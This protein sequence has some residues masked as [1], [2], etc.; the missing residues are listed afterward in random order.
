MMMKASL[1]EIAGL[2]AFH[3]SGRHGNPIDTACS[4]RYISTDVLEALVS[5][6]L[7]GTVDRLGAF[8]AVLHRVPAVFR[9]GGAYDTER[10]IFPEPGEQQLEVVRRKGDVRVEVA[11]DVELERL[12]PLEAGVEGVHLPRER[13]LLARR[14]ANHLNPGVTRGVRFCY[15]R[16]RIR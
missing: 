4:M 12:D 15:V 2:P 7:T 3:A 8:E 10:R 5:E 11:D 14:A 16:G 6:E 1:G 13:A 9:V